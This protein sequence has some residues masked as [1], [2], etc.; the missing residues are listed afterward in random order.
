MPNV[1]TP[2]G[3]HS[4]DFFAPMDIQGIVSAS[5]SVYNRW[6]EKIFTTNDLLKGWDGTNQK[7]KF[8]GG[9]YYWIINYKNYR[10]QN[11][12]LIGIVELL[13]E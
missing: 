10:Q 7:N 9:V 11:K 12:E 1:F 4:N 3:E 2:N 8:S 6:G 13:P 5:L